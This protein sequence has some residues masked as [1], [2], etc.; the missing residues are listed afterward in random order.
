MEY[1]CE[2][3]EIIDKKSENPFGIAAKEHGILRSALEFQN[4]MKN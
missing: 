3:S 1:L 2:K 4:L